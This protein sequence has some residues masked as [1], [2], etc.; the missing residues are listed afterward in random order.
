[1]IDGGNGALSPRHAHFGQQCDA[2]AQRPAALAARPPHARPLDGPCDELARLPSHQRGVDAVRGAAPRAA[3]SPASAP[4]PSLLSPRNA[5]LRREPRSAAAAERAAGHHSALATRSESR[6]CSSPAAPSSSFNAYE[7]SAVQQL[8]VLDTSMITMVQQ[9]AP[10]TTPLDDAIN[11]LHKS[12]ARVALLK[13]ATESGR[14]KPGSGG[15]P[16]CRGARRGGA[17]KAPRAAGQ[18]TPRRASAEVAETDDVM[19]IGAAGVQAAACCLLTV[20]AAMGLLVI[21][22]VLLMCHVWFRR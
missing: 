18:R 9:R 8:P 6:R 16:S 20:F 7:R 3:S 1:M 15:G 21:V 5:S 14:E 12:S 4:R 10:S 17:A 22:L 11:H 2:R 19:P 13:P